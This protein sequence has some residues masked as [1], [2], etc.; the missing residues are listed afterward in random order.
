M[1]YIVFTLLAINVLYLGYSLY[2]EEPPVQDSVIQRLDLPTIKLLK[3]GG[4]RVN[5]KKQMDQIVKNPVPLVENDEPECIALGPFSTAAS[6]L[7]I[8]ERLEALD[9]SV[10]LRA[11]DKSMRKYDH[12]VIISPAA[13]RE[14]AFRQLRELQAQNIDSYVITRGKNALAISLGVFSKLNSA[15]RLRDEMTDSGYQIDIVEFARLTRGYWV[16]FDEDHELDMS[17]EFIELMREEFPEVGQQA[18]LC[19]P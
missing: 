4:V 16:F 10:E 2:T 11:I 1:R 8:L 9:V 15:N 3:E 14:A 18:Q 7:V 5:R 13:S 6:G 17:E 19:T 12:Q